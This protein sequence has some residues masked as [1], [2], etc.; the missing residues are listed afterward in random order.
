M[1]SFIR[2]PC[3]PQPFLCG[4]LSAETFSLNIFDYF[5]NLWTF[6][7]TFKKNLKIHSILKKFL[8]SPSPQSEQRILTGLRVAWRSALLPSP[9]SEY[10]EHSTLGSQAAGFSVAE[11]T[12]LFLARAACASHRGLVRG[13]A[14][15]MRGWGRHLGPSAGTDAGSSGQAVLWLL[16]APAAARVSP[17]HISLV[18]KSH[19]VAPGSRI[20]TCPSC[21]HLIGPRKSR[22]SA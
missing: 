12:R 17:V 7:L 19:V 3:P 14:T 2:C 5:A 6:F 8:I 9:A 13:S 22:G 20:G 18:R 21:S 15:R 11:A 10:S 1:L 4:Y 16:Q